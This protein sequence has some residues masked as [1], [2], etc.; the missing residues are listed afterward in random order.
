MKH[1]FQRPAAR[2]LLPLAALLAQF[3]LPGCSAEKRDRLWQTLDPAGYKHAHMESFRGSK[4]RR[5]P[6]STPV[7]DTD[8]MASEFTQ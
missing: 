6:D 2:R 4:A 3:V 5:R 7:P 8:G 1:L